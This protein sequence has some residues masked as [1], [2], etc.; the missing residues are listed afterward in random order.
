MGIFEQIKNAFSKG[1]EDFE[2]KEVVAEAAT[3]VPTT[4]EPLADAAELYTV[5]SGDTLW[6]IADRVYGD[7][8]KYMSIFEANSEVLGSPDAVLPGQELNI[9]SQA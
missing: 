3:P 7:G 2:D 8:E 5:Q 4:P 9:P 1:D 6:R